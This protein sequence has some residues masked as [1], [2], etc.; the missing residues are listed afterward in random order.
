MR[1]IK[2]C[3][4]YKKNFSFQTEKNIFSY[5][6]LFKDFSILFFVG[7]DVTTPEEPK[8]L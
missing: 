1:K 4:L 8:E 5:F 6:F 3:T 2:T 7:F